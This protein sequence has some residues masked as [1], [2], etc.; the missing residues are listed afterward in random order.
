MTAIQLSNKIP[1][2]QVSHH[3]LASDKQSKLNINM[4]AKS[5]SNKRVPYLVAVWSCQNEQ[6]SSLSYILN[7]NF[8][9]KEYIPTKCSKPESRNTHLAQSTKYILHQH[10]L[11]QRYS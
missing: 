9:S 8:V 7:F 10:F 2:V 4:R 6:G 1:K 5:Q 3:L 11:L